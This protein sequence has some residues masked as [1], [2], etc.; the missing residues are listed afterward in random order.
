MKWKG[1]RERLADAKR[2]EAE[3]KERELVEAKREKE[4]MEAE[5]KKGERAD[6]ERRVQQRRT[7]EEKAEEDLFE[8]WD[9]NMP[10]DVEF[11]R[12][13]WMQVLSTTEDPKLTSVPD[14]SDVRKVR[15]V[16]FSHISG[17]F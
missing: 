12:E 16:K 3:K 11:E 7:E 13:W 4:R 17:Y 10:V 15:V 14:G 2:E 9:P 5:K 8:G 1:E 6:V